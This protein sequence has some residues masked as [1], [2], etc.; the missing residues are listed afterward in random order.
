MR[1]FS[2]RAVTIHMLVSGL[3]LGALSSSEA[4]VRPRDVP[5]VAQP[6]Q[7]FNSGQ[8]IQPI[9]EG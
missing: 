8:D 1:A 7:R 3:L 5:I 9:F 6:Q 4:Q 2:Y